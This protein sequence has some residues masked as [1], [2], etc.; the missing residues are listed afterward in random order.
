MT[1]AFCQFDVLMQSF[2]LGNQSEIATHTRTRF[3]RRFLAQFFAVQN[4]QKNNLQ[5]CLAADSKKLTPTP[6]A[7][8]F[9]LSV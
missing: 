9:V 1:Y 4:N 5:N 2:S 3:K 8:I 6:L 7:T